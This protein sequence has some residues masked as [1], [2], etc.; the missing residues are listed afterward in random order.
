MERSAMGRHHGRVPLEMDLRERAS[1]SSFAIHRH[2]FVQYG[3]LYGREH[4]S[5]DRSGYY[6]P[7]TSCCLP[8]LGETE[9]LDKCK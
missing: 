5:S 3:R 2:D 7:E 9:L 8:S 4:S 1:V 6:I